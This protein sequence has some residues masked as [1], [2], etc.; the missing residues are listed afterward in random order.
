L[1]AAIVAGQHLLRD[2]IADVVRQNVALVHA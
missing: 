1:L 2:A